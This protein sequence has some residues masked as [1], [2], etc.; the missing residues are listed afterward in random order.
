MCQTMEMVP[1][2]DDRTNKTFK[3]NKQNKQGIVA[4]LQIGVDVDSI[5]WR[6]RYPFVEDPRTYESTCWIVNWSD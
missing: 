2:Q 5:G 6:W 4:S 3:T 1:A